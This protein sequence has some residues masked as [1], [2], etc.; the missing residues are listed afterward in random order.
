MA[1]SYFLLTAF[2][3]SAPGVNFATRLAEILMGFPVCGLRPVR[4]FWFLHRLC[5]SFSGCVSA[6]PGFFRLGQRNQPSDKIQ[7]PSYFPEEFS[8][9]A[10]ALTCRS[11]YY[12]N[13]ASGLFI[14]YGKHSDL[15]HLRRHRM[16]GSPGQPAPRFPLRLP[17][18]AAD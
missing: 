1:T 18:G 12:R 15:L 5:G 13:R 8:T 3:S 9:T 17:G 14:K 7:L 10:D 6:S 11:S 2:F 16:E 4:A